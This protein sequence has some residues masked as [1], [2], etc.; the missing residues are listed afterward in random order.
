M[1]AASARIRDRAARARASGWR[2]EHRRRGVPGRRGDH[3]LDGAHDGLVGKVQP[4]RVPP[5][6]IEGDRQ[7]DARMR[8]AAGPAR[9]RDGIRNQ[10]GDGHR[11]IDD[12]VDE[13]RVGAILEQAPDQVRE[14]RLVR[15]D[16]RVDPALPVELAGARHEVVHR[17]AHAVQALEFEL[18][19]AGQRVDRGDRVRVVGRELRVERV[20]RLQH[21]LRAREVGDVRVHLAREHGVVGHA[22]HLRALDLGVPVRA[23]DEPHHEPP[24]MAAR[25][26]DHPVHRRAGALLVRLHDEAESL[27]PDERRIGRQRGE[28]VEREF[29]AVGLLGVDVEADVEVLRELCQFR[30]PRQEFREHA[31]ALR[32]DVARMQRRQL[33]RDPVP[34]IHAGARRGRA[35]RADRVRVGREVAERVVAGRR[36]LSQHV[37]REA[38]AARLPLAR[39]D[40]RFLDRAAEHELPAEEP[41]REIDALADQRL[42]AFAQQRCQRLLERVVAVRIDQAARHQQAPRGRVHEQR[43]AASDMRVP[44]ALAQLVADQQVARRGIRDAQQRLGEAHERDAL[45]R[46][47]RELEHQRVDAARPVPLCAHAFREASRRVLRGPQCRRRHVCVGQQRSDCAGFVAAI[48]ERDACA[49][50]RRPASAVAASAGKPRVV[51][52]KTTTQSHDDRGIY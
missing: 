15:S 17:F 46:I 11:G 40:E 47:E 12:P 33:D 42:A 25:E 43:R 24:A 8:R 2:G 29:E 37:E 30:H 10:V 49:Q 3:L 18:R 52:E 21:R 51:M 41:H 50:C 14:Q 44:V 6:R 7:R 16:R 38:I 13:R 28:E 27:P 20:P 22:V 39:I 48:V 9:A 31:V 35:D 19:A 34:G 45:A 26:R 32:P 1:S 23:L 4:L 5:V 36:G